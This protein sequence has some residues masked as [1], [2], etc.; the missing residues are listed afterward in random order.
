MI[1]YGVGFLPHIQMLRDAHPHVTQPWYADD[2]G[3]GGGGGGNFGK[4]LT[5][6][7]YLQVRGTLRGYFLY[8]NNSILV[9]ALRNVYRT[10]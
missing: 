5:Q 10:E 3:A 8:P 7:R 4:I 1:A 2:T 9:I 6:F